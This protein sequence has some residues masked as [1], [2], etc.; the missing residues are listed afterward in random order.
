MASFTP[1]ELNMI[2]N[3]GFEGT[4]G[5]L[6][7]IT[8]SRHTDQWGLSYIKCDD[9]PQPIVDIGEVNDFVAGSIIFTKD[10][11]YSAVT[12]DA[13]Y[14]PYDGAV[15]IRVSVNGDGTYGHVNIR[16]LD[17]NGNVLPQVNYDGYFAKQISDHR[18]SGH[19]WLAL[20]YYTRD[21]EML[22]SMVCTECRNSNTGQLVTT[23]P[24]QL[25]NGTQWTPNQP[26]VY[27][28]QQ[29]TSGYYDPEEE[30][31]ELGEGGGGGG[32]YRNSDTVG[33][34][35][36]P[37][38]DI[39]SFGFMGMYQLTTLQ[40]S[41]LSA[42]L[43]SDNFIE[44]IKKAWQDPF[45]NIINVS[46]IP[47]NAELTGTSGN[48]KIGNLD[49]GISA[50][51]LSKS[52][53]EKDFGSI[54][55]KELY[56][57][58]ADYAPFTKLRIYLPGAGIR[59]INPDDYMDGSIHLKAFIDIFSGTCVYQLLSQRHGR[60]HVVDHYEANILT[61]IPITGRNFID[62]YKSVINGVATV[63][64]GAVTGQALAVPLAKATGAQEAMRGASGLN[65]AINTVAGG[66]SSLLNLKP[67]YEK[68]GS[69]SGSAM[70]LSVQTPYI[71]FDTPQLR[72]AS[73]FRQLHGYKSNVYAR[74]GDCTGFV[75]VNYIDLKGINA[76]DVIK[77]RIYDSLINGV[78]I[79]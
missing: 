25:V 21:S 71:F 37:S 1:D 16:Y 62:A 31:P 30:V 65:N 40:M 61:Q 7:P 79:H 68:T 2:F 53:Y 33:F 8:V 45:Q 18:Y 20:T 55:L 72:Q 64:S 9:V 50:T 36:L 24:A 51:K 13:P 75:S 35:G 76:P 73:N 32:W 42:Y 41:Q 39:L 19:V 12:A 26:W 78:H 27:W 58:F 59:D 49:S 47:L 48:I 74:L 22:F 5:P 63:A 56:C 57:N 28:Y 70:R 3:R 4:T 44:N 66:T 14:N 11:W 29:N 67:T 77:Q 6:V 60:T 17:S 15:G 46:F 54:N 43:W 10:F 34:S 23:L 38:L 52:L 69:V